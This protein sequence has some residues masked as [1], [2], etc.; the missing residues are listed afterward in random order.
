[1]KNE[2]YS[3]EVSDGVVTIHGTLTVEE[4]FDFLSF[5]DKKGFDE[6]TW[7]EENS[8][9]RL[10]NK[11]VVFSEKSEEIDEEEDED[12]FR[13]LE[14]SLKEARDEIEKLKKKNDKQVFECKIIQRNLYDLQDLIMNLIKFNKID[15]IEVESI[16]NVLRSIGITESDI[17]I[18]CNLEKK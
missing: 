10:I 6:V 11:K 3:I 13:E 14:I 1:M 12:D 7:G 17:R 5:Y 4:A 8:C 9:L 2:K 18:L 16:L 15:K